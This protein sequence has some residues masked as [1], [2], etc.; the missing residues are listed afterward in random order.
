MDFFQNEKWRIFG[1]FR[2]PQKTHLFLLF[3][4]S[5]PTETVGNVNNFV[6]NLCSKDFICG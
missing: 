2:N 5:I 1:L 6:E 4:Q 3:P